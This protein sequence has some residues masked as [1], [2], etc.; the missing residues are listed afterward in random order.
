MRVVAGMKTNRAYRVCADNN[1]IILH[2]QAVLVF[3]GKSF[4]CTFV[5]LNKNKKKYI[6]MYKNTS[7]SKEKCA[8]KPGLKTPPMDDRCTCFANKNK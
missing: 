7:I 4:A 1:V 6:Y 8:L 5:F 3:V 2:R